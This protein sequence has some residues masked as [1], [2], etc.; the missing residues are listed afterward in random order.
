MMQ[1]VNRR[2]RSGSGFTL[3]ELLVTISIIG[4]LASMVL[5]AM[6]GTQE[7]ARRDRTRAQ[8][9]RIDA[10]IA[11]KIESYETH[12]IGTY[13]RRVAIDAPSSGPEYS[14]SDPNP[15]RRRLY[16][17][18]ATI[19]R[20]DGMREL[21]RIELPERKADIID[22]PVVLRTPPF[23]QRAYQRKAAKL[24]AKRKGAPLSGL[25][26][27]DS[28]WSTTYQGAECLYLILSQMIDEEASALRYF[29]DAEI[30]DV[31]DD[32][33]PEILDAWGSPIEFLRWAPGFAAVGSYQDAKS[34]EA[35]D[36]AGIYLE[37][38]TFALYPLIFSPGPDKLY[39]INV[40]P[41]VRYAALVP[42]NNPY[43]ETHGYDER[44]DVWP[45]GVSPSTANP[46]QFVAAL[47]ANQNGQ[48][49][50]RDNIH[51]HLLI[52]GN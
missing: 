31:D 10:L 15:N 27:I 41:L 48:D 17:R 22:P 3:V 51:N 8:I 30:G 21:M 52:A 23:L 12:R 20:V 6:A 14:L 24:L 35:F 44:P 11:E 7:S 25:G 47:D 18:A 33:M 40:L 19:A 42:P 9:A 1:G 50:S 4:I 32:G 45:A 39:E 36:P 43:Y 13:I 34:P 37:K 16:R 38:G 49:D 5:F 46:N 29:S 26:E 2:R 28:R